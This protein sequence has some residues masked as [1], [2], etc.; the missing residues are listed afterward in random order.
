[1]HAVRKK[2]LHRLELW[3]VAGNRLLSEF[4]RCSIL[5]KFYDIIDWPSVGLLRNILQD[6][7][8][9]A[10]IFWLSLLILQNNLPFDW[11]LCFSFC[12]GF[13]R[14]TSNSWKKCTRKPCEVAAM[15]Y[16]VKSPVVIYKVFN[17]ANVHIVYYLLYRPG[18]AG[19]ARGQPRARVQERQ[20]QMGALHQHKEPSLL[21]VG[22]GLV[23][24]SSSAA[25]TMPSS[26]TSLFW[27]GAQTQDCEQSCKGLRGPQ[28]G[29]SPLCPFGH[30]G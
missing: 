25:L 16:N 22:L 17:C 23:P 27:P 18:A 4:L 15:I 19:W 6:Q 14:F 11:E 8:N 7:S 2:N 20:V 5:G 29:Y 26:S 1:M 30:Q 12:R 10:V 21:V 24:A 13:L 9:L 3:P 28:T